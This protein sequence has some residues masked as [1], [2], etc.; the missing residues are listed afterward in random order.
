M[1]PI[2]ES[3][4]HGPFTR[5]Q[6]LAAG[7]TKKMLEGQRFVVVYRGVWRHR[8]HQMT[9]D[10]W[11]RAARLA[12]PVE[13]QLTGITRLQQLGLDFGPR[14]PVRFVI[15]GELHL[16]FENVFLHRTVKLPPSDDVGVVVPAAFI[17]YCARAR[18]IDV[19]KVGDWLLRGRHMTANELR[20]LALSALWRDGADEAIW[21]LD[22]LDRRSRSL[23]ESETRAVLNFAGLPAPGVNVPID[24][25]EDVEVVGDLVYRGYGLA[26]EYEGAHHQEDR[27]QYNSDLDRYALMRGA[28]V[29]YV[30]V[31]KEKLDRPKTLVGE[32]YRSLLSCGYTG[33][34]PTFGERW[35]QL[36]AP[37]SAAAGPRQDRIAR[38]AVG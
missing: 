20:D 30:Q 31:T 2:P 32:V 10:D 34:P 1:K 12:L 24:V 25:G 19:I 18:V 36:F 14:L 5:A 26:V 23:K 37:L 29:P 9:D 3:L 7:A 38:R 28:G 22:H 33:P 21:V 4:L 15:Q 27:R 11:V 8:D 17:A 16:A 13:A 6:A 35:R